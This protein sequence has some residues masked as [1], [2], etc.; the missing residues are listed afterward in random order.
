MTDSMFT[1]KARTD[2]DGRC[3]EPVETV[4]LVHPSG[5]RKKVFGRKQ[6][7]SRLGINNYLVLTPTHVRLYALGGRTGLKVKD[8][9][10]AWPRSQV[11]V[12]MEMAERSSFMAS[13]GSSLEW[14]VF[15]LQLSGPDLDVSVD[16]RADG[17]L[18][19]DDDDFMA[20]E[21]V[22][23]D[24]QETIDLF[25]EEAA[26]TTDTVDTFVRALAPA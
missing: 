14:R 2:L 22:E 1:A 20:Q 17:G 8:E 9:L 5:R 10:G 23:A 15:C 11:Q 16:V 12:R 19:V 7:A 24:V 21:G 18:F 25:R 4:L 3:P 26:I 6:L 13:T